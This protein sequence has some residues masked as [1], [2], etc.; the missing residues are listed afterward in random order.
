MSLSG[1]K[2]GLRTLPDT[3]YA[4]KRSKKCALVGR[5]CSAPSRQGRT[6][7]IMSSARQRLADPFLCR[8]P[9]SGRQRLPSHCTSHDAA[10]TAAVQPMEKPMNT[11]KIP[12]PDSIA[13]LPRFWVTHDLTI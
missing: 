8:H 11:P 7:C 13:E 4:L 9:V 6:L 1:Q 12:H 3:E 10:G 5:W 2:T